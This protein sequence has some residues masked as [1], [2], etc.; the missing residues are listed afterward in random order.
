M[1]FLYTGNVTLQ[2]KD[3]DL[4]DLISLSNLMD[5]QFLNDFCSNVQNNTT[6]FNPSIGIYSFIL[7]YI[8]IYLHF[9]LL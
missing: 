7:Y 4:I 5:C 2:K 9:F 1:E 8:Y 6:E 3:S